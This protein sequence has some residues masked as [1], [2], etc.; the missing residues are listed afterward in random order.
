MI[1]NLDDTI[2]A[3]STPSGRGGIHVIRV[4]GTK[5]VEIIRQICPQ[6]S[7]MSSIDSHRVYYGYIKSSDSSKILDEVLISY[8]KSG[9]SFTMEDTIEISCHGNPIIVK[10]ILEI[11]I[12]NGCRL[13]E[14]GEFTYRAYKSGRI[15]L[16]Q[17]EAVLSLIE[18]NTSKRISKSLDILSGDNLKNLILFEDNLIGL[19]SNLEAR[20]D[21]S[22]ED[23][24][25]DSDNDLIQKL[26]LLIDKLEAAL[27][28]FQNQSFV[29][30]GLKT[31]II[32]PPNAGK[33]SLFNALLGTNRSI[34]SS[35]PGTTRDYLTETI[36]IKG[37]PFQI[38]DTAGLRT[39]AD[40]IEK[41]GIDKVNSLLELADLVIVL[42][43]AD[44]LN[45]A[46][47]QMINSKFL[48]G[49]VIFAVNKIDV[50]ES[51]TSSDLISASGLNIK[52]SSL[53]FYNFNELFSNPLFISIT[54]NFGMAELESAMLEHVNSFENYEDFNILNIRHASILKLSLDQLELAR[55]VLSQ[56]LGD[57]FVLTHLN[58]AL[59]SF[60]TI[61]NEDNEE[62]VRDRIFKDFCLGK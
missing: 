10:N 51:I 3:Q 57:E 56:N 30:K 36:H 4:S 48:H 38:I 26:T 32:G 45:F 34:I 19:I 52:D 20:I 11:L 16:P 46:F 13:A 21:F 61:M 33:S 5:S 14:R 44:D 9:R 42:I 15:S 22:T 62:I 41:Y 59:K 17:A 8:F 53:G 27:L 18:S 54:K 2:C 31:I 6:L 28:S 23:I 50:R 58:S 1:Y 60:F 47:L 24:E 39:E 40:E 7:G 25:V 29:D 37:F 55:N 49:R 12:Q 35:I 43:A